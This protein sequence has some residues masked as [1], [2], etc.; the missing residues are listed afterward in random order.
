[1]HSY[2]HVGEHVSSYFGQRCCTTFWDACGGMMCTRFSYCGQLAS[3]ML[4]EM[5]GDKQ[6]AYNME[7]A[8]PHRANVGS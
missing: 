7:S 2:L 4:D 1:M 5:A 6:C 8:F 3:H